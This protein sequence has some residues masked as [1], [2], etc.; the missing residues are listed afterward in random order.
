[1][2][3]D[4][5]NIEAH[6]YMHTMR[7]LRYVIYVKRTSQNEHRASEKNDARKTAT[8]D[9]EFPERRSDNG[10]AFSRRLQQHT[11]ISRTPTTTSIDNRRLDSR[12]CYNST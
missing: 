2:D 6:A 4:I 5:K 1:M 9:E 12:S 3:D 8:L 7:V 10:P 11:A